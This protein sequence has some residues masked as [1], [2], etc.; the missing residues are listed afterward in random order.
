MMITFFRSPALLALG[1]ALF[2]GSATPAFAQDDGPRY[3]GQ[4]LEELRQEIRRVEGLRTQQF[5]E[6]LQDFRQRRAEQA[7]LRDRAQSDLAAAEQRSEELEAQFQQNEQELAALEEQL[8]ERLGA[9]GELFGVVRQVAGDTRAQVRD[10]L[11][12]AQ[13]PGRDVILEQL[14]ETRGLPEVEQLEQL[15][16]IM[17]GEA[18]E[19]GR[20]VT[21]SAE[22]AD[23]DGNPVTKQVTRVGP[24]TATANGEYLRWDSGTQQVEVL[25][26]QPAARYLNAAEN[27]EA[28]ESGFVGAA[29]DPSRG[30]I[31]GLIVQSPSLIERIQQGAEIGYIII[32]LAIFGLLLALY[33]IINRTLTAMA[34]KS[35]IKNRDN[36]AK[37]NPLG[38]V[39]LAYEANKD[40]DVETLELKLDDAILKETPKLESGLTTVKVLAAV[41]PLLG[42]L[43]TVTGMILTFQAITLFGTGDPKM[44][45][46]GISQALITTVLGL[47]AAIPLLLLHSIAAGMS[48]SVIDTLEGQA[49]GLVAE[50]AEAEG[51]A[52]RAPSPAPAAA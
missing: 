45:A 25:P 44:M 28:A 47:V 23:R 19:Q 13:I 16:D 39:I 17:V 33:L 14:A 26:R 21:F 12:S 30:A 18:I 20:V 43:G 7:G 41:S 22:A 1:A 9:F 48:K 35:Q 46:G 50:R 36:P 24:F 51:R 40:A 49:A 42:L 29:I 4:T 15:W 52:P 2:F 5:R 10:S 34:V 32:A 37:G 6:R 27:L 38:R 11:I 31:L 3:T 8:N